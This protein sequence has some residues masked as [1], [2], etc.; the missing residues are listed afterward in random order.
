[1]KGKTLSVSY[2]W[3][4]DVKDFRMPVKVTTAKNRYDFIYPTTSWQT[5]ALPDMEP[6]DFLVDETRFYV[7]IEEEEVE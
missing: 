5:T 2:K 6:D 1:M 4:A 3:N 7:N